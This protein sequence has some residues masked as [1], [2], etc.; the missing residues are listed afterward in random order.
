MEVVIVSAVRTPIGRFGGA[1]ASKNAVDLGIVAAKA[2]IKRAGIMPELIDQSIFGNVYQAGSGQNVARQIALGSGMRQESSAMT[3]NE[4][5]GS[6]LKAIRLGQTAIVM[7]DADV[8]LVGGTESMSSVPYYNTGMRWGTKFGNQQ[9][10]DGL[11]RDG[12]NDAF[13]GLPMGVTAENVAARYT[14]SR[15]QQ[16][17][18]ALR[19]HQRALAAT[20]AGA[21]ADE[22]VPVTVQNRKASVTVTADEGPR[23]DTSLEKLARLRPAFQEGGSVTAG[24]SSAIN[25]GASA[26]IMMSREQADELGLQYLAVLDG[27]AEIGTDPDYMGYAP[28]HVVN[29]LLDRT[30]TAKS[31]VDLY[32][33]N[34]AFAAQSVAVV[35]DLELDAARVN[36]N[37]GAI[38]LGHPLGDSGARIVVT[39]IHALQQRHG[40]TGVA[41]LCIGGG[42]GVGLQ[43]HVAD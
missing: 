9:L 39:L 21:F 27:Y 3:V 23:A 17:A 40:H 16:D 42:L 25:D 6:G 34:E 7:G 15:E 14:V 37:G 19:S 43:L 28:Y 18:F 20:A 24:N 41:A 10:V 26:L 13:N 22:I 4:V 1:L 11:G 30:A 32:E 5:C 33:I 35:R 31:A 29:K 36:V 2:A 38:A 8:V 12:L